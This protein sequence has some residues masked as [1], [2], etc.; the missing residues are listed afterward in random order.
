[1]G[2]HKGTGPGIKQWRDEEGGKQGGDLTRVDPPAPDVL[3]VQLELVGQAAR[4]RHFQENN[5]LTIHIHLCPFRNNATR[6][7]APGEGQGTCG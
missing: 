5:T 4:P 1:M 2:L 6:T 3:L 7:E